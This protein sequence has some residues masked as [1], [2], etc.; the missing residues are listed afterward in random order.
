MLALLP[1]GLRELASFSSAERQEPVGNV[2]LERLFVGV[3]EVEAGL[4][5]EGRRKLYLRCRSVRNINWD[6]DSSV[7]GLI[8]IADDQKWLLHLLQQPFN[9]A[10]DEHL[11]ERTPSVPAGHHEIDVMSLRARRDGNSGISNAD[12]DAMR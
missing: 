2:V 4:G 1:D 5:K 11:R 12:I 3:K 10:G 6:E 7:R 8:R 9:G